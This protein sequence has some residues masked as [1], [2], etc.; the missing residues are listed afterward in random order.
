MDPL[1]ETCFFPFHHSV[2]ATGNL[3]FIGDLGS[4]LAGFF[5]SVLTDRFLDPV[6]V[7]LLRDIQPSE[8]SRR[9]RPLA[10]HPGNLG[11]CFIGT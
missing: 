3:R 6:L 7:V 1:P 2:L 5:G 8:D 11:W 9:P 4:V 10:G